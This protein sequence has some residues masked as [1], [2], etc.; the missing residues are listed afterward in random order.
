MVLTP[1]QASAQASSP[2]P[3][4]LFRSFKFLA[5]PLEK[6]IYRIPAGGWQGSGGSLRNSDILLDGAGTGADCTRNGSIDP[7]GNAP[8]KDHDLPGIAFLDPK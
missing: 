6:A 1:R 8:S 2:P 3:S 4:I 7:E 5:L